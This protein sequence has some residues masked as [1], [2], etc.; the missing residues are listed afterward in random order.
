M[1]LQGQ[2]A[3]RS[4]DAALAVSAVVPAGITIVD[5]NN[6]LQAGAF[7]VSMIAGICAAIYYAK[8]AKE[9]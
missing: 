5:V 6:W 1:S 3:D 4:A 9:K 7:I 8:K 2:I